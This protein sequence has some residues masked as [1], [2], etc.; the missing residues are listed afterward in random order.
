[1]T[2]ITINKS[3]KTYSVNNKLTD[4]VNFCFSFLNRTYEIFIFS[5]FIGLVA[6]NLAVLIYYSYVIYTIIDMTSDYMTS[7]IAWLKEQYNKVRN[8]FSKK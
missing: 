3:F 4:I 5:M 6:P 8:Y 7:L 1:M 2:A